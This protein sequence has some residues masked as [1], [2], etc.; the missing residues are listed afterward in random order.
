MV[1]SVNQS[2]DWNKLVEIAKQDMQRSDRAHDW[3]HIK[4][5]VE[6][7]YLIASKINNVDYDVLD[8]SLLLH[9]ISLGR[10]YGIKGHESTS[11]VEAEKILTETGF[12]QERIPKVVKNIKQHNRAY[13]LQRLEESDFSI[14]NKILCDAD[15]LDSLGVIGIIRMI[16]FTATNQKVPYIIDGNEGRDKSLYGNLKN[17]LNLAGDMLTERG[18]EMARERMG[19]IDEFLRTLRAG[20]V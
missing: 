19:I 16:E 8:A 10:G 20:Q 7:G 4:R 1:E 17:L 15:R 9:D 5:V 18:S 13:G 3:P 11:A 14:E 2:Y 6:N 12:W